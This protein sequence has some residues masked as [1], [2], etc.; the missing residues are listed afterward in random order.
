MLH[1]EPG[2]R[3]LD[4]ELLGFV[5]ARDAR[6][7]VRAQHH[8]RLA[9]QARREDALAAHVEIVPVDECVHR[10]FVRTTET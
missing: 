5:A 1:L 8:D 2:L 9:D 4:A 6:S 10:G 7:I 3:H